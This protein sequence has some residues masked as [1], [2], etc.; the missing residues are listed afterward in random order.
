MT[1]IGFPNMPACIEDSRR[2]VDDP[3]Q[4]P[5][6]PEDFDGLLARLAGAHR[7]LP[8][9]Y[10]RVVYR[11]YRAELQDLG[12]DEFDSILAADPQREGEASLVLDIAHAILQNG[13]GYNRLATDAYQEVVADLYDGFLSAEDRAGVKPPDHGVVAP[14]VKWGSPESG[15]YTWSVDSTSEYGSAAA[16]VSLPPSH[17]RSGLMGWSALGHET[18][19]HDILHAD[20]GL[21]LE[22]KHNVR[23]ALAAKKLPGDLPTYWA[24][25]IDETASDVLGILNMGP[26]AGIGLI[27]YFRGFDKHSRLSSVGAADDDHPAD[28]LRGYLAAETVRLLA[29][30]ASAAWA[31]AL[32]RETSRDVGVI[33][34]AGRTVNPEA[35]RRSAM[36]VA[37]VLVR[38][39]LRSLEGRALEQI[40]NWRERDEKVVA[41]L[42]RVLQS[43]Q[44]V[45]YKRTTGH[46]AAHTVAAAVYEALRS[47]GADVTRIFRRMLAILKTMH[48]DNPA[49][50]PQFLSRSE[51]VRPHL[52]RKR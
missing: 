36:I 26:A 32:T 11:P 27:A 9:L 24:D 23:E 39:P 31:E 50:G 2:A 49:W 48:N 3:E 51:R 6:D 29:F 18:A 16:I 42:R 12:E 21:L 28:I 13:E 44:P 10:R 17:A 19:G 40:Q 38:R 5:A 30:K 20:D 34:L 43:S 37:H 25:R 14:L 47:K 4:G 46:Y 41:D 52:A 7:K 15:P 22:L 1:S 33:R 8:R 45:R 35:V